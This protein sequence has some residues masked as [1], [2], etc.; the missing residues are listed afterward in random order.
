MEQDGDIMVTDVRVPHE[1]EVFKSAGAISIR[2][3][4]SRENRMAR[5]VLVGEDDITEVGLDDVKDWDYVI[6]NNSTYEDLKKKL[7][8]W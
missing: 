3:E 2:I 7:M 1:Y 6:E 8:T 4:T 5:G